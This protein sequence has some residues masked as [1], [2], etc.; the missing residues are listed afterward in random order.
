[1]SIVIAEDVPFQ[2]EYLRALMSE[3]FADAGAVFETD[4]GE[5][6][7]ELVREHHPQLVVLDIK[8]KGN[9]GV[10]AAKQIWEE[11][12]LARI[13]FWSQFKDEIYVRELA[14]VVPPETVY[15]YVLKSSA[16]DRLVAALRAVLVEEQCWIDPEIRQVQSRAT[17]RL[18]GLTDVEYEALIDIAVGLTDKAIAR[19]RYLSERGVQNRLRELYAR[20]GVDQDQVIDERWGSTYSP[21]SRAISL[22]I[23]RGLINADEVQREAEA[24]KRWLEKEGALP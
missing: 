9:S 14:K 8:L 10:K 13:I 5:R 3:N 15:G 21:R 20:L 7:L 12:P 2:R 1:M 4:N 16:D 18:S 17:N 24:L 22:A 19:R 11:F 23:Q 6:A